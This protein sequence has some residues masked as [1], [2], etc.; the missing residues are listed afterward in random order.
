MA[1]SS[2]HALMRHIARSE[3]I[4]PFI[5]KLTLKAAKVKVQPER[6]LREKREECGGRS[7]ISSLCVVSSGLTMCGQTEE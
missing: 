5:K 2:L 4:N 3:N 1:K 6:L 7:L